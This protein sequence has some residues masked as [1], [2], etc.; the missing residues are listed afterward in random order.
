MSNIT[1]SPKSIVENFLTFQK[2]TLQFLLDAMPLGDVVLFKTGNF[3]PSYVINSPEYI[4]EILVSKDAAFGKG[5]SSNVLRR[6]IGDGLL[7]TE[8]ADHQRQRSLMMPVFYKERIK[9][10][11]RMMIEECENMVSRWSDGDIIC[12]NSEMMKLTLSIITR[13]M[14]GEEISEERKQEVADAVNETIT[15]S[16]KLLYS[17]LQIP[18]SIPS[19]GNLRHKRALRTLDELVDEV[20]HSSQHHDTD[21]GTMVGLLSAIRD[22][23]GQPLPRKEIRDQMMTM[24]IAGHE[25]TANALSWVWYL[26]ADYQTKFDKICKESQSVEWSAD[27]SAMEIYR[28]LSYTQQSVQETLRLYPP[29]WLILREAYEDVTIL[30]DTFVKGSSLLISPYALHRNEDVFADPLTFQPERFASGKTYPRFAYFP[31]G[32]GSRSCIGSTFAMMEA[33]LIV[34]VMAK[35]LRL[36]RID[37]HKPEP[38]TS[39]SLR[40]KQNMSMRVRFH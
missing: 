32:G 37:D 7:T 11:G 31:F 8:G 19:P 17:P 22:A 14:F 30:G 34:A 1:V 4:Q 15:R 12:M 26:L 9:H 10:Y 3:K 33:T 18:M 27:V 25:T 29:A 39:V 6:T 40:M 28:A 38:E 36:E 20:L 13:T 16:S 35:R 2:D 5:R 21:D 24:L 23:E